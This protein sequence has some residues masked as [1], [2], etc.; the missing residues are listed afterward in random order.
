[1]QLIAAT[2]MLSFFG[3]PLLSYVAN[4]LLHERIRPIPLYFLV[5][6][7]GY[8]FI[9]SAAWAS[10]VYHT[11]RMNSF[12]GQNT[13]EARAAREDWASDTGRTMAPVTG[14]PL[15]A[16]WTGLNFVVLYLCEWILRLLFS[17]PP[18]EESV[19]PDD[20]GTVAEDG[21]PYRPPPNR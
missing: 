20:D 11:E 1:M 3:L 15:S 14:V 13:P 5:A 2:L 4:F 17:K 6:F 8:V 16:I 21:N 12:E 19:V 10:D 7:I 18:K 9:V